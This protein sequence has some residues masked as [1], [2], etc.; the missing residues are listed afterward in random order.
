MGYRN[1]ILRVA[2]VAGCGVY[3]NVFQFLIR[4]TWT[5]MKE[6]WYGFKSEEKD[7]NI[8]RTL[9]VLVFFFGLGNN[10]MSLYHFLKVRHWF[11][12]YF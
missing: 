6:S 12:F 9:F 2:G 7:V 11:H 1:F 10:V 3:S 8:Y 5:G 4:E